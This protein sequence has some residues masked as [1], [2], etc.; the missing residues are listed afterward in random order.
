MLAALKAQGLNT[1]ILSN[2]SPDMLQGAVDSADLA[3]LLDDVLSVESVGIFKP[4]ASVYTLVEERFG[5]DRDEVLFV[6][7]NGWDATRPAPSGS[8]CSGSTARASRWTGC[9]TRPT[10]SLPTSPMC[11]PSPG[12]SDALRYRR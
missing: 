1:A 9:P 6:S 7:S 5:C 2:G 8:G 11:P 3:A 10:A 4:D 12:N